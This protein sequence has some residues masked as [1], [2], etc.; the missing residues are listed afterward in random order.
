MIFPIIL[1]GGTGTRLWP[2]SRKS[3]PKQFLNFKGKNTLLQD[4]VLFAKKNKKIKFENPIILTN[5]LYRFIIREQLREVG[6]EPN[7][8]IIEPETKNTAPAILAAALYLKNKNPNSIMLVCPSDHLIPQAQLFEECV[9]RGLELIKKGELVT[10]GIKPTKP[11]TA[12]GYLR[13]SESSSLI[14]QKLSGF[15]EKPEKEKAKEMLASGN[16]LW[17]S[18][19]FLFAVKDIISAFEKY[20]KNILLHVRESLENGSFDLDF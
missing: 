10:F 2:L 13:L 9:Q 6:I 7:Q 20:S 3:Y 1:A 12:Y 5:E 11:E 4:R 17:N 14:P 19:I 8:I 15:I 16:Y 18:G